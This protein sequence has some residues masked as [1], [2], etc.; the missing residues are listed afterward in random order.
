MEAALW[1]LE[2]T[3]LLKG[4]PVGT[5]RLGKGDVSGEVQLALRLKALED[6]W[7]PSQR[8]NQ[9]RMVH[10]GFEPLAPAV[11]SLTGRLPFSVQ[12]QA[13]T[14]QEAD[15]SQSF[16]FV[17]ALVAPEVVLFLA[18]SHFVVAVVVADVAFAEFV[19]VAPVDAAGDTVAASAAAVA[20]AFAAVAAVAAAVAADVAAAAAATE[21]DAADAAAAVVVAVAAGDGDAFVAAASGGAAAAEF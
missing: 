11:A 1:M 7:R 5:V 3:C 12:P 16:G 4:D 20:V 9:E 13:D 10:C 8:M 2:T 15:M 14:A 19:A 17:A 21:A 18:V 6:W